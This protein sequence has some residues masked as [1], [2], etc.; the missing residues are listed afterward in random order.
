MTTTAATQ[1]FD[2]LTL[3]ILW[4]RLVTTA[5]E[6][7][8]ILVQ[9]SFSTVVG[10][11][12]D[13]G[14]EIMDAHGRSL[15]HATRS[16]PV[17]N[18]TMPNVTRAFIDKLGL[19]T[20]RPGDV[21]ITNDSWMAAGHQYDIAVVTP[22]FRDGRVVGFAGSIANV[23]DIGGVLNDNLAREAYEEG[24]FIP[25]AH[26]FREGEPNE[27]LLDFLRWNV[28]VPEMVIGDV[29]AEAAANDAGARK[30]LALL[31]EYGLD[32]LDAL[33]GEVQG[34]TD[35]AMRRAISR[36]PPGEYSHRVEFD[37]INV[38][39]IC[40]KVIFDGREVTVDFEGT[41][42]QQPM[43][44][45]NCT[46][47]YTQGQTSYAMKYL[48]IPE[49]PENEGCY[50]AVNIVAPEG[51]LLNC[52]FPASVRTRTRSGWYIHSA[53]AGALAQVLPDRVMAPNGL[54][55]GIMAYGAE[56]GGRRYYA[57][58]FDGGGMG[59]GRD[60][61]GSG[62]LIFPSSASNVPVELFEVA[63]PILIHEKELLTDSGGAGRHRGGPGQRVSYSRLP[64]WPEPVVTNF[65]A[66]RMRVPP[67]GLQ[68]G[69]PA[70]PSRVSI[71]GHEL[72][73]EEFLHQTEGFTLSDDATV[74][75]TDL[76]GGGGFGDPRE[77]PA[78]R[79]L[80]D[81]RNGLV[82]VEAAE[83]EYGVVIDPMRLE[84]DTAA[85]EARR[86]AMGP[87]NTASPP[88]S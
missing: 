55:G 86:A 8:A 78:E 64:G 19:E 46:F 28:R 2:P 54:M 77:R 4:N 29:Y 27:L 1:T 72:S 25:M 84:T 61:D 9:T 6:M 57:H 42:P 20:M 49:V 50:G 66:H 87:S 5:D 34:R 17:F 63:A 60:S 45:I 35:A 58:F 68:G 14:C 51:S 88:S 10:A 30:I 44:G 47:S 37:E 62:G 23:S 71:D 41:S 43:G 24:L 26:L 12:N 73:R 85:T 31:D 65:W 7:A 48:L 79:V 21:F 32:D 67:F 56:P 16:M 13:F 69:G 82:S 53:L 33:A 39:E 75:T 15:S 38:L 59:A 74:C 52:R 81:V 76:A 40:A 80:E 18:Q 22:F 3:E 70:A 11:A 36:V 83:R